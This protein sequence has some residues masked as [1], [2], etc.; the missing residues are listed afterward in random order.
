MLRGSKKFIKAAALPKVAAVS[1]VSVKPSTTSLRGMAS[2]IR[3]S[4]SSTITS[5]SVLRSDQVSI[6]DAQLPRYLRKRLS[7]VAASA[8]SST[9]TSD[10][11]GSSDAVPGFGSPRQPRSNKTSIMFTV[12]DT[13]GSLQKALSAFSTYGVNMTRLE[14]KP[15]LRTTDYEF[16]VD[17]EGTPADAKVKALM[18][19]IRRHVAQFAV[20]ESKKV[21]WF[22]RR[23]KDLDIIANEILDAGADLEAD[24]P[25]FHD[26]E[27]R[28]RRQQQANVA[29]NYRYGDSVPKVSMVDYLPVA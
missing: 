17:F 18:D 6:A 20:M 25:G 12:S 21:A 22:P 5:S 4:S 9:S 27:Y 19:E 8:S 10:A 11:A 26:K 3:P 16:H 24:H 14:S 23:K 28:A 2:F 29:L 1:F 15:S 13:A 7:T